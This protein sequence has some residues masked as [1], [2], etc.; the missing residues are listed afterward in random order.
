MLA[1]SEEVFG[2]AGSAKCTWL[3]MRFVRGG[4]IFGVYGFLSC[5]T[6]T[7][8]TLEVVGS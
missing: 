1:G 6:W 5:G 8:V 4:S 3:V 2:G 7:L